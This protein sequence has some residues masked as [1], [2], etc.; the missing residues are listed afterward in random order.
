MHTNDKP[1]STPGVGFTGKIKMPQDLIGQL[2]ILKND[3]HL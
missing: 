1:F 3:I 2:A